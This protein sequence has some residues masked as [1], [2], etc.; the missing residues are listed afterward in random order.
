MPG[1]RHPSTAIADSAGLLS[2][3]AVHPRSWALA[4]IHVDPDAGAPAPFPVRSGQWGVHRRRAL[5]GG[6]RPGHP[7]RDGDRHGEWGVLGMTLTAPATT[8]RP[9]TWRTRGA[10]WW[11]ALSALAIAVFTPLPYLLT[12]LADLGADGR[13]VAGNYVDESSLVQGA[14]YLHVVSGG[15]ALL[16]SP[17]QFATRLRTRAPHVHR[18][19]GRV[20]V[21]SIAVAGVAGLLLAPHNLAG[22]V[23]TA[24]FGL[25]AVLW[26]ACAA[27]AF[28]AVRRRDVAA[29][30]RWMVRTFALTYA[31]VTL[32]LWLLVLIG[33]QTALAGVDAGVAFDRAY[34][35]VPFLSWVPNLLVAEW[36]LA[37]RHHRALPA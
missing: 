2:L 15:L 28:R 4:G 5:V 11:I 1:S 20:T 23:G 35:L 30:R 12:P 14:L 37:G 24:G 21:A 17:L 8:T 9:A 25:L 34:L 22:P 27:T 32:R 6:G 19:I 7:G 13:G 16:L 31:A 3:Q 33:G 18:A 26:L 29:H 36:Y 10:H